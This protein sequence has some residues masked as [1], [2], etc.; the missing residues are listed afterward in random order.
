[1]NSKYFVRLL[2]VFAL[3]FIL[4][5]CGKE[6]APVSSESSSSESSIVEETSEEIT[7]LRHG[8]I[9]LVEDGFDQ[10]VKELQERNADV[11]GWISL[12]GTPNAYPLLYSG[13]NDF[14]LRRN[15]DKEYELYGIPYMDMENTPKMTDQNTVLYG[16]MPDFGGLEQFG[17]LRHYLHQDYTDT[18]PKT[19]TITTNYGIFTYRLFAVRKV[20]ADAPYRFANMSEEEYAKLLKDTVD[21][22]MIDFDYPQPVTTKERILTLSTCTEEGDDAYRLAFV[23]VLD[24]AEL[25]PEAFEEAKVFYGTGAEQ[26]P[27]GSASSAVS[28]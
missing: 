8:T 1:M 11:V 13:D 5:A 2:G 4:M 21:E 14:Y 19:V 15:I 7:S 9:T 25:T 26:A 28:Q 3:S 16:H 22:N 24:K 18:A 23:G 27:E 12:D 10:Q 17:V 20:E 6:T